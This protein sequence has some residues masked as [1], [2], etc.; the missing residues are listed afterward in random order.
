V[1]RRLDLATIAPVSARRRSAIA[2]V[3]ATASELPKSLE[4]ENR[5]ARLESMLKDVQAAVAVLTKRTTSLQAHL[6]HVS[7]QIGRV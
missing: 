7:A 6:D 3:R 4:L 5:V 2:T 1:T